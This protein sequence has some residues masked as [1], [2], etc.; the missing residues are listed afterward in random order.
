MLYSTGKISIL[1]AAFLATSN[2]FCLQ[3]NASIKLTVIETSSAIYAENN[4]RAFLRNVAGV[5]GAT[6]ISSKGDPASASYSAY[7]NREKDWDERKGN[8]EVQY[9]SARDLKQAL[10]EVAPMNSESSKVFCPNGPSSA[11]SPLMENK[12][13]DRMAMPSV[14][15]RTEDIVGNSIPGFAAGYPVI[16]GGSQSTLADS[17]GFPAYPTKLK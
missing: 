14:F 7:T 6:V 2:A 11:V 9:S 1:F 10:R 8:G 12:C 5:V 16:N 17:G 13:G 15:G 4:R 3:P